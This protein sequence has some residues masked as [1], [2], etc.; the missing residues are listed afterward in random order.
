LHRLV[1]EGIREDGIDHYDPIRRLVNDVKDAA[2][3]S[4][5]VEPNS[6]HV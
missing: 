1:E 6:R 3:D 4:I 2:A 5:Q